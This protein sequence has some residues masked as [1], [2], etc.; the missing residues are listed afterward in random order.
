M[1]I[2]SN[3][4][5]RTGQQN[6]SNSTMEVL[7]GLMNLLIMRQV[8]ILWKVFRGPDHWAN[9]FGAERLQQ[10]CVDDQ[11]VNAFSKLHVDDWAE[12]FDRQVGEEALGDS[13]SDNWAHS[14]DEFLSGRTLQGVSMYFLI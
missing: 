9:E 1:I 11:W 4:H 14:Y 5:Q 7:L 13:S 8:E 2:R 6:I 10:E 3:Q 12:E